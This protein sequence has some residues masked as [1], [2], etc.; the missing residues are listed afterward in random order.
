MNTSKLEQLLGKEYETIVRCTTE[1][2]V[3]KIAISD[4]P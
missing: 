1:E 4:S 3:R 2:A